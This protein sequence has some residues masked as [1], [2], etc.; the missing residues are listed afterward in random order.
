MW[1]NSNYKWQTKLVELKFVGFTVCPTMLQW[2]HMSQ[3]DYNR[4]AFCKGGSL[5]LND[6]KSEV[7]EVLGA[8]AL[9]ANY[10]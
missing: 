5:Q 1:E 10:D 7:R 8:N 3:T 6:S 2:T 4:V 9:N